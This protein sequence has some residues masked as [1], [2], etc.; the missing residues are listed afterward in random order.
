M[1][2]D[3]KIDVDCVAMIFVDG[4]VAFIVARGRVV[5]FIDVNLVSLAGRA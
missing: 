1:Q 3:S 5:C 2:L 4:N